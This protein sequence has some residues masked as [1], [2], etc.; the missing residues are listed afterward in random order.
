MCFLTIASCET[1]DLEGEVT[2]PNTIT[3]Y[4]LGNEKDKVTNS[5]GG[6]V[7]MGGN[8][9][10]DEAMKWFLDRA[11]GGDVLIL[12]ASGSDGY[13]T[14]LFKELGFVVNSVETIVFHD[15]T[16]SE[17]V[18][19]KIDRAEAIWFAGGNQKK[20]LDYW[21]DNYIQE[22]LQRAINRG[23]VIGGTSAGMAILGEYIWDGEKIQTDF[24]R[25]SFMQNIITDTH[26]DSRNRMS[27]HLEFISTIEG[28]DR[29]STRLN[30]SH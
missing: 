29:K 6:I 11:N 20:Y 12:R 13:Q 5:K 25:I 18:K 8:R 30:S 3:S 16:T 9:E 4:F 23:A 22:A 10:N 2:I 28:K 14:Y 15:Q 19:N 7:M 21:K 1:N 17:Y 26:Y 24:L 27:R